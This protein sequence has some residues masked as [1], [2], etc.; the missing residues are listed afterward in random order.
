MFSLTYLLP[1]H[2]CDMSQYLRASIFIQ[3]CFVIAL[4]QQKMVCSRRETD[5]RM[6]SWYCWCCC[7]SVV[8]WCCN[9]EPPCDAV[10]YVVLVEVSECVQQTVSLRSGWSLLPP[11]TYSWY[12]N[13]FTSAVSRSFSHMSHL[14]IHRLNS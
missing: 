1:R 9:C 2:R 5:M 14:L 8:F 6:S 7:C 3:S 10:L 4:V 12:V 13:R 11:A